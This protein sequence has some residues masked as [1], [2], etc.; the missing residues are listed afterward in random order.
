MFPPPLDT[1]KPE[2]SVFDMATNTLYKS[3]YTEV[4]VSDLIQRKEK[5]KNEIWNIVKFKWFNSI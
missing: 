5:G 1:S 2:P 3:T 4:D